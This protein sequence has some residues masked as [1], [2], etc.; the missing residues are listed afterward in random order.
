M[1]PVCT[2]WKVRGV[3]LTHTPTKLIVIVC[4]IEIHVKAP[5]LLLIGC[6]CMEHVA[7]KDEEIASFYSDRLTILIPAA[8]RLEME[9]RAVLQRHHT[10]LSGI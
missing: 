10:Q 2:L 9:S 4:N 3:W 5:I 7:T 6:P 8:I 1:K